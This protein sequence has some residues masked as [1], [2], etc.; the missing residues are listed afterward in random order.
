[1]RYMRVLIVMTAIVAVAGSARGT[2]SSRSLMFGN[3][4]TLSSDKD[5]PPGPPSKSCPDKKFNLKYLLDGQGQNGNNDNNGNSQ[6]NGKND[7]DKG[8]CGKGNDSESFS[9]SFSRY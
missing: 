2:T 4:A 5:N 6:D 8:N 7:K 1:M 3:N 9:G